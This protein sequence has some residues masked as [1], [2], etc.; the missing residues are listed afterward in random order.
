MDL[1]EGNTC[2]EK[3]YTNNSWRKK[4]ETLFYLSI[5]YYCKLPITIIVVLMLMNI[6][7]VNDEFSR[8]NIYFIFTLRFQDDSS[9]ELATDG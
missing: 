4:I 5:M 1:T 8:R 6:I 2:K 9:M 7:N 3:L